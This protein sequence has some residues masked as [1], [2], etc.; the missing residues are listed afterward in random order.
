MK[1]KQ[2]PPE[3]LV[4]LRQRLEVLPPRARVRRLLME[5]TAALYGVSVHTLYR[6]LRERS[7]PKGVHRSD[8]GQPRKVSGGEMERYCEIIAAMKLRSSNQKGRH[9]STVRALELLCEHGMETPSGFIQPPKGL[10]TTSTVNHYLK[11]WGY[12][13][14]DLRRQ[15]PAV[16]FQ[17]EQSN[18]CWQFDLSPSD[19]KHLSQPP[20]V[21]SGRG[22]PQLMLYSVVDDRSGA[23]YQEYRCVYGEDAETALRF[24]FNAMSAKTIEGFPFQGI[25]Q[26]LYMDNG[27]IAKSRVF[28]N[29]MDCLGV[30]VVTHLPKGKDGRRVTAR[31]KGKVER[32]FR[33]VKEAHE[34]LYHFHQPE[35]EEEANRWLHQYLLHYNSQPHRAENHSRM[36]DWLKHLPA[37]GLLQMCSWERFCTFAREPEQRKVDGCARVSVAG[38]AYEVD[39]DLAGETVILWWG[40][41]DNELYVEKN[42]QR[43]GPY[44]PVDGPIPL[45]RYR[46]FKKSKTQQRAD[47]IEALSKKLVLPQTAWSGNRELQFLARTQTAPSLAV[48]PF[49]DPDPFQEF[50]YPTVL[51]AKGAIADYLALPLARLSESERAFIDRLLGETLNKKVILER[52]RHYFKEKREKE[53]KN[54]D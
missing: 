14:A 32:P 23:C 41:F 39:P 44:L 6:A 34:T 17:A 1:R 37:S 19:L 2:I 47:R 42:G 21:Q 7:R 46:K 35:T 5:E 51:A 30:K 28:Q 29:V 49:I 16:R 38:V 13:H 9:L 18:Q 27:P 36:E 11:A 25:P 54:V 4:K 22:K 45:H 52:V 26:M 15:P 10:L 24:L 50:T 40:L 48:V 8:R 43:Y 20:W 12:G 53:K 3:A 31:A 33:T